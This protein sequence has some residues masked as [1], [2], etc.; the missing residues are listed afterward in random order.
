[1]DNVSIYSFDVDFNVLDNP[2]IKE[3]YHEICENPHAGHVCTDFRSGQ[4][5]MERKK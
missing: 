2:E 4:R 5:T 1:M 3:Y